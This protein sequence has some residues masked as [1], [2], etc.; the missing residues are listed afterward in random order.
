MDFI[1][2]IRLAVT[3]LLS[4][5][6]RALLT[7]LGIIIGIAAVITIVTL[8]D[9][10]TSTVSST[11]EEMG[12]KNITV[13]LEEKNPEVVLPGMSQTLGVSMG[14]DIMGNMAESDLI[15]DEMI[16]Q[17]WDRY[18]DEI[19]ALSMIEQVGN[20]KAQDGRAYSNLSVSGVNGDYEKS[21]SLTLLEGRFINDR[22]IDRAVN[23]AVI[24]DKTAK[25]IFGQA[26]KALAQEIKVHMD[27]EIQT[28]T[29][30]GIYEY[31]ELVMPM[32]T[33]VAEEDVRTAFY[34][35]LSTARKQIGAPDGCKSFTLMA[36][37]NI[38]PSELADKVES[39]FDIY[40]R[41]NVNYRCS[42]ASMDTIIEQMDD[43]MGTVSVAIAVIAGISLLVGGIGVMNIML[44]S[45]TERTREI[46]TRKA[47]GA[48]NGNIRIQFVVEAVIIC[49]IGGIIGIILG[50]LCGVFGSSILGY[51][52]FP[53]VG[54]ILIAV[55]FSMLI[56]VFFGYY[57]ANKAARM[58][59]IEALRYE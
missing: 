7:M 22:D 8:G 51:P 16:G 13:L 53:G 17:L 43:I 37:Q 39:F 49:L 38:Q 19:Q 46:G 21:E 18:G 59:P 25:A 1:E 33:Q 3:G 14:F 30:V 41:D 23:V 34:I 6:M 12:G 58:D 9:A 2:N 27:T 32:T 36:K 47:L 56:G 52:A 57:P 42:A 11:M 40:Y 24:S 4:N 15:S 20:G 48:T 55:T 35:P 26:D 5:K 54:I 31:E 29:V 10:I 28:Y 45:I 44:V 50:I